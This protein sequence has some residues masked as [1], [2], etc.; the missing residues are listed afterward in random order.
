VT[1]A[2]LAFY[3]WY[4]SIFILLLPLV[5]GVVYSFALAT[6]LPFGIEALNSNSAFLGSVIVGNG[7]NAGI[8]LL[9]R[10][11]EER[12]HGH[13]VERSLT[14]AVRGASAGTSIA[15]L[16]A[17][18]SYAAL[19]LADFRGFRQFGIIGTIGMVLCWL[20]TFLLMPHLIDLC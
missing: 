20:T 17:A 13:G 15:S 7:V 9:A 12:R 4:K 5:L 2:I 14:T 10:Y 11:V 19:T 6:I 8:I 16:G 1:T 18:T 3:R